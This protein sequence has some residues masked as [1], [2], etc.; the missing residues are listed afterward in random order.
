MPEGEGG[1]LLVLDFEEEVE[2]HRATRVEVHLSR[3]TRSQ[4]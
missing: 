2:G 4:R 1:V 3:R